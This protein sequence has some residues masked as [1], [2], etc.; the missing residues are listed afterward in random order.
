[1]E[2]SVLITRRMPKEQ[3]LAVRTCLNELT[4]LAETQ[5]GYISGKVLIRYSDS[6][7]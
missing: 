1:M 7:E 5:P 4:S 6:E 3:I 2:I